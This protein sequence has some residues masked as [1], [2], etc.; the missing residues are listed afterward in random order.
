MVVGQLMSESLFSPLWFRIADR[1]PQLRSDV[2]VQRQY[3]R[4]ELWYVL[5]NT[6]DAVHY[7]INERAYQLIG[8][9]DGRRSLQAIWDAMLEELRDAAPTQDEVIR[10]LGQIEGQGL[11]F[12]DVSPDA[13]SL[14]RRLD[15]RNRRGF[16]NPFALRIPLGDPTLLLRKLEWLSPLLFNPLVMFLWA[17]TTLVALSVTASNW[18]ALHAHAVAWM[19]TSRY[20]GLAFVAFPVI[21]ALH[22][23]GHALAVRRWGGGVHEAGFSLF[24]LVPAPY[25]NASA[26]SAFRSRFKRVI[27]SAA[28]IMVELF[29]AALALAIWLNVQPGLLSD[30]AFVTMFIAGVSTLLFNGNPLLTFDGYYVLCDALDLPNLGP[31]SREWWT[32]LLRRLIARENVAGLHPARGELKWLLLYAPLSLGYRFFISG[33][34]IFWV[35]SHSFLL[36]ALAGLIIA[37]I[38]IVKPGW[39][40][41]ARLAGLPAGH[42]R[43]RAVGIAGAITAVVLLALCA[44]PLPYQTVASAVVWPPEQARVRPGTDGFIADILVREGETVA[45]GDLLLRLEDPTL[46]VERARLLSLIERLQSN[47]YSALLD[48]PVQSQNSEQELD[49]T[50]GDLQRIEQRIASLDV[51]AQADGTLVMPRQQDLPGTLVRQGDTIGY[52]LAGG[53]IGVRAAV[54]EY[55]AALVHD[56]TRSAEV[57]L[58][59][60]QALPA[61]AELV[62]DLPATTHT[63]PSAALGDR[64]GGPYVTDPAD[65]EGLRSLEPVV[66]VDLMLPSTELQRLGGRAWVRFEHDAEPVASR[67]MRRMRQLLLKHVNPA[68]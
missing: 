36:G 6:A 32:G 17:A 61:N 10:I 7:R 67:W 18:T 35:G 15:E 39:S 22:E 40:A 27:V 20:L 63:L 13:E 68:A 46:Y 58:V 34:M 11:L 2:Q 19:P 44:I 43:R 38:L 51:R 28:G 47:G 65:K 42:T 57:F 1:H 37:F 31:R 50:N 21:K 9:C 33:L 64:G 30:L 60:G 48:D 66:I 24:A 53:N 41:I 8:R 62:R 12:Y 55:D 29:L 59:E 3:V 54:P 14:Q 56:H 45:A 25:V 26:A 16:I 4:G 49:R 23:L 52:V 5:V